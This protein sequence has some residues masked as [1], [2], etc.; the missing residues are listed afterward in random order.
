MSIDIPH[1]PEQI[2]RELR[3]RL[4]DARNAHRAAG[5]QAYLKSRMPCY[6]I[7]VPQFRLLTR[8]VFDPLA[9]PS[10]SAWRATVWHLWANA[11][12]R[13]ERY[14]AI[15]LARARASRPFQTPRALPLYGKMIA[16]GAW[17]DVVDEIAVQC[18]GPIL[19]EYPV[20]TRPILLRWS[21]SRDLWKR[22][23]AIICQVG[24]KQATDPTF[25]ADCIRPALGAREFFLRKAIG[26]AL[27]QYARTAPRW[28][29]EYVHA[30][31][32][33]LS[34]LSRREAL[35]HLGEKPLA[36]ARSG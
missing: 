36:R 33:I 8:P 13:E 18:V 30:H 31:E 12:F 7:P 2:L 3:T 1:Q 24:S 17:W 26:W 19:R 27:R 32:G 21:T 9:F 5:M 14:A 6:G 28:V 11:R 23:A 16:S 20:Q 4:S 35:R 22:R 29:A 25:L 15:A 34:P 10:A